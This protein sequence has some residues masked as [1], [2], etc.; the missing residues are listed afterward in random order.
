MKLNWLL[1]SG[2]VAFLVF[3]ITLFVAAPFW[4]G[5]GVAMAVVGVV[6]LAAGVGAHMGKARQR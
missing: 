1:L 5:F 6:A 2:G 4:N 3:I